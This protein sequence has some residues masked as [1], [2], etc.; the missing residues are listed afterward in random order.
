MSFLGWIIF[1]LIT[2][3]IASKVVNSQGE[4]CFLNIALGFVGA[5]VGGFIYR[6]ISGFDAFS[7]HFDLISML[8]AILGAIVVLLLYHAATGRRGLR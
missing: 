6:Q 2:G 1:G 4:G 5:L 8:V 7:F 3:F